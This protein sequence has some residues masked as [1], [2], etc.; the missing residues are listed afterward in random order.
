MLIG[1]KDQRKGAGNI[2]EVERGKLD[3]RKWKGLSPRWDR[4]VT[5]TIT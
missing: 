3:M 2:I 1:K 4:E 5:L